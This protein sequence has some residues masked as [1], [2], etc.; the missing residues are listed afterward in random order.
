MK[1]FKHF[2][3]TGFDWDSGNS[4]KNQKKHNVCIEEAESAFFNTPVITNTDEKHSTSNE[5][6]FYLLG[7]SFNNRKL[8]IVF[9]I[10]KEKIRIISA[11]DMSKKERAIYEK[12]E[13]Q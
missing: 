4:T 13:V 9:T 5:N 11:R 3:V 7:K 10:R 1:L 12:E 8:F 2:D 6:R